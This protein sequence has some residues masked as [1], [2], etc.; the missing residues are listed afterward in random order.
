MLYEQFY[1]F[2]LYIQLCK[3]SIFAQTAQKIHLIF[4]LRNKVLTLGFYIMLLL[5]VKPFRI[6]L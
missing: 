2:H 5:F 4:E 3:N 1:R 6:H